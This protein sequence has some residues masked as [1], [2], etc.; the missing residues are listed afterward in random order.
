MF[1]IAET[2]PSGI[3]NFHHV[4]FPEFRNVMFCE[5]RLYAKMK[6][7][8]PLAAPIQGFSGNFRGVEIRATS[9]CYNGYVHL[10]DDSGKLFTVKIED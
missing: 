9:Y 3:N 6:E 1:P 4:T 7:F 10:F 2:I 5:P 8:L